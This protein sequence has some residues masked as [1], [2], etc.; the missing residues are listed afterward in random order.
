M[1]LEIEIEKIV[2]S[3]IVVQAMIKEK[4]LAIF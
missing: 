4:T 2:N 3:G 1:S